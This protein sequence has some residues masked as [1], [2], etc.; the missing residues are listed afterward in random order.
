MIVKMPKIKQ[1]FK[2]KLNI[3]VK[4]LHDLKVENESVFCMICV[5]P[6][7]VNESNTSAVSMSTCPV[8]NT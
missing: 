8:V 6:I 3:Y 4:S 2:S 5:K 7:Q 1:S